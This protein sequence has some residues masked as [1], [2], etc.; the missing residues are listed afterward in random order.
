MT[1]KI[2]FLQLPIYLCFLILIVSCDKF[3]PDKRNP[4]VLDFLGAE[5]QTTSSEKSEMLNARIYFDA[6]L[7]MQG[8]VNPGSTHYTRLCLDLESAVIVGDWSDEK[9]ELFRFGAQVEPIER[10]NYWRVATPEFYEDKDINR[11]TFIQEVINFEAPKAINSEEINPS[12][13]E[14][15]E[16]PEG[17][18]KSEETVSKTQAT[19]RLVVIVTD[20]FQDKTDINILVAQLKEKI[21][22]KDLEVGLLGIR[23][24]FDGVV[25]DTGIGEVPIP[26]Q[27]HPSDPKTFRPF[28]LLVFGRYAD[29][30]HYFDCLI[31]KGF[32]E[33]QTVIFS[34]YLVSPLVSFDGVPDNSIDRVNLNIDNFVRGHDP[35]L[36]QFRIVK[37]SDDAKISA[38]LEYVQPRH[39]MSFDS[40]TLEPD[41]TAKSFQKGQIKESLDAKECMKVTSTV[42]EKK[43]SVDFSLTSR[44]LPHKD[45]VYFYEVTLMPK[46]DKYEVPDWVSDWDMGSERDG[47]KTVNLVNFVRDLTQVTV[48]THHPKIAKFY[49]CIKK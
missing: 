7:S 8:F 6:T 46:T 38:K 35:R 44:F 3:S 5:S 2:G 37:D 49:F 11:Q 17:H 43:L 27:S 45:A 40:N 22:K 14:Q 33:A 48:H 24:H 28:Y 36:K 4:H 19:N 18:I 13:A 39:A 23:S 9:V 10:E 15:V 41:V 25:Y 30:V 31:T 1:R 32:P 21:I 26:Y 29:I 34:Q 47:S 42:L 16:E 12:V 20:L